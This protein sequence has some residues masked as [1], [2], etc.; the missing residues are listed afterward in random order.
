MGKD[1]EPIWTG[2]ENPSSCS[3]V[4]LLTFPLMTCQSP[5]TTGSVAFGFLMLVSEEKPCSA[6]V[7]LEEPMVAFETSNSPCPTAKSW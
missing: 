2:S 7:R 1:G 6:R 5:L 3:R 4:K